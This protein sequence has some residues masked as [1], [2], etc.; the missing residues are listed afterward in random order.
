[1]KD[2][3]DKLRFSVAAFRNAIQVSCLL[4]VDSMMQFDLVTTQLLLTDDI[5]DEAS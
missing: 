3:N 1:M 2:E 5:D 4:L